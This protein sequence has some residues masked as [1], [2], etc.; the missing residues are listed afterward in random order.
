M[1]HAYMSVSGKYKQHLKLQ[2]TMPYSYI[3]KHMRSY[4][5]RE[6]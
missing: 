3:L 5:H 2:F 6:K 1:R 4:L